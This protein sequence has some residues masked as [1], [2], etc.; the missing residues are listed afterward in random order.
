MKKVFYNAMS[1]DHGGLFL[2][3]ARDWVYKHATSKQ[4]FVEKDGVLILSDDPEVLAF[5]NEVKEVY[6]KLHEELVDVAKQLNLIA[7]NFDGSP[8]TIDSAEA[9]FDDA[10]GKKLADA[11]LSLGW[12]KEFISICP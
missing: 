7:R 1:H 4:S 10:D 9:L 6:N 5:N 12:E 11:L 3:A 8:T 2:V